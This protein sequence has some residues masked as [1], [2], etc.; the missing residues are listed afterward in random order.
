ME[1]LR[2]L[3]P[4]EPPEG[5]LMWA[6]KTLAGDL[7]TFG[8][9]YQQE[10]VTDWG[11]EYL[12]DEWATPR[13]RRMVRVH[14]S[15]CGYDDLYHPGRMLSGGYGFILP[16]SFT[17]VEGGTVY[18]D[19]ENILCPQCRT[20]VLIRRAAEVRRKGYCVTA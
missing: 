19:G 1:D 17:E 7:D 11:L 6:A 10:W 18:T 4:R 5:F 2:N 9:L 3:I 12:L 13:K 14:C 20:P 16:E 8:F 15:C